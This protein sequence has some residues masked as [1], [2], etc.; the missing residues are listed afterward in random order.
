MDR[1]MTAM[2]YLFDLGGVIIDICRHNCVE[3]FKRLGFEDIED[4][5]GDYGQKGVF[6]ELEE[7][8]V[9]ADEFRAEVRT[10]LPAGVTDCQIDEAFNAFITGIP[11]PRLEALRRLRSEGH[12]LYV[13]SNTN[14]VMWESS[15]KAA[16][17]QEGGDINTYFDGVVTSFEAGVCKPDPGIFELCFRKFGIRPEETIFFDDSAANCDS[18]SRLGLHTVHLSPGQEFSSMLSCR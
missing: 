5:L 12:K 18:A 7:G 17:A 9:S 6:L 1:G 4:Y 16:F 3:A 15:I 11:L 2:N 13:I 10:H 8:K 14:P